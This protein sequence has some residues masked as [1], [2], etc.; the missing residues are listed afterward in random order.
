MTVLKFQK[1]QLHIMAMGIFNFEKM[2]KLR[3]T[4]FFRDFL[5]GRIN[6]GFTEKLHIMAIE[7][8]RS[9]NN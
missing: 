1:I 6:A 9:Y 2:L 3:I 4:A 8:E 7:K 5:Q